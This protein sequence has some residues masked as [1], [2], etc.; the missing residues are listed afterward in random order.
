MNIQVASHNTFRRSSEIFII[1]SPFLPRPA[2]N[3][4]SSLEHEL[5]TTCASLNKPHLSC[6]SVASSAWDAFPCVVCLVNSYTT[7]KT[8]MSIALWSLSCLPLSPISSF[9]LLLKHFAGGLTMTNLDLTVFVKTSVSVYGP[10]LFPGVV[11][12]VPSTGCGPQEVL[13]RPLYFIYLMPYV[14]PNPNSLKSFMVI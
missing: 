13:G 8:R 6:L 2:Q 14:V 10:W 9:S 1:W 3:L 5:R 12:S 11:D 7:F 4:C